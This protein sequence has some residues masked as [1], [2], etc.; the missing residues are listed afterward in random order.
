LV[1]CLGSFRAL[2][3]TKDRIRDAVDAAENHQVAAQKDEDRHR[4][5]MHNARFKHFHNSLFETIKTGENDG[6]TLKR[7]VK[8][9]NSSVVSLRRET[10]M[11]GESGA[12]PAGD[13][14]RQRSH[15]MENTR[16]LN[17]R[18]LTTLDSSV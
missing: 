16:P 5:R 1:A 14:I 7:S 17:G 3:A 13:D 12:T 8:M 11:G 18:G 2:F 6:V 4:H 10:S 15:E 9:D